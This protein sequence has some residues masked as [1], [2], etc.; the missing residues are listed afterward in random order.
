MITE[1][2]LPYSYQGVSMIHINPKATPTNNTNYTTAIYV[3][4]VW[5]V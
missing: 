1:V 4:V 2:A 5:F 3:T